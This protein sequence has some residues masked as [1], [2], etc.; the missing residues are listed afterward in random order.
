MGGLKVLNVEFRDLVNIYEKEI[1]VNTKNKKKIYRFERFKMENLTSIYNMLSDEK[2]YRMKYNIFMINSPKYRIV[3]SLNIKDK[4]INHY[5]TRFI[6]I[7]KLEKFL[8]MRN[9]ATRKNMGKDFGIKLLK[10]YLEHFKM[11]NECY[12]L[13]MDISKYFYSI[14]HN[15]LKGMIKEYLEDNEYELICDII[16]STNETYVNEKIKILK[17][18]ELDRI[19]IRREEV[20]KIPLYNY[21]KGLPIGN[22]SS[23][24]LSIFYLNALDHKIVHDYRLKYYIRYMDDIIILSDDRTYLKEIREKII[25]ELKEEY[26]LD[27]NKNKTLIINVKDG[28]NFCG[29]RF[30]IIDRK[31]VINICSST[32]QRIKKRMKEVRHLYQNGKIDLHTAFSSF[33]TYYYS[34]KYGSIRKI[35]RIVN[36]YF[37]G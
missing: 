25:K 14:D 1:R 19:K 36:K 22:M 24:F 15:K 29:Y 5:V 17:S 8:D 11:K 3:M 31:T 16:D 35:Q 33:N 2:E 20:E 4:I 37:F 34:F 9:V 10:K 30:R 13:K 18:K 27:V 32:K 21:G 7:S 12:V 6:L 28:F 23:Q 26:L